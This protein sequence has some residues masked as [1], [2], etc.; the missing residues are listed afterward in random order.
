MF[1]LILLYQ[2]QSLNVISGQIIATSEEVTRKNGGFSKGLHPKL[3]EK[4]RF[5]I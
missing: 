5:R 2:N 4:F 1:L 3:P